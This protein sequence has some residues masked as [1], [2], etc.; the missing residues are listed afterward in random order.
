MPVIR[1]YPDRLCGNAAVLVGRLWRDHL[2]IDGVATDTVPAPHNDV[3]RRVAGTA[4]NAMWRRPRPSPPIAG[5][6]RFEKDPRLA[7][8]GLEKLYRSGRIARLDAAWD[9]SRCEQ[10]SEQPTPEQEGRGGT[11][12]HHQESREQSV[13]NFPPNTGH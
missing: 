1:K 4:Q 5:S 7:S 13:N 11:E 3:G 12:E 8:Y 9:Q 6:V 2:H 10:I